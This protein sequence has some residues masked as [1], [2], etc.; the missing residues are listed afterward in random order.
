MR[1]LLTIT[2]DT[3]DTT[4]IVKAAITLRG[5]VQFP[6]D[7]RNTPQDNKQRARTAD[8]RPVQVRTRA[9]FDRQTYHVWAEK[10]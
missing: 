3:E 6:C 1:Y 7:L 9:S 2:S 5:T 8:E 4:D 10:L